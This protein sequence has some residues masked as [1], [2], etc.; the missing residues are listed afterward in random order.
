MKPLRL[1]LASI[2]SA[3]VYPDQVL[4]PED[5][6]DANDTGVEHSEE[7]ALIEEDP[8]YYE[9]EYLP[10][11]FPLPV[12]TIDGSPRTVISYNASAAPGVGQVAIGFDFP[13]I[14]FADGDVGGTDVVLEYTSAG[15]VPTARLYNL[16]QK[17]VRGLQDQTDK[18]FAVESKSSG[19]TASRSV[20]TYFCNGTF[21]IILPTPAAAGKNTRW[22]FKNTGTGVLTLDPAG[23][24]TI[25]GAAT[26]SVTDQYQTIEVVSDGTNYFI[27]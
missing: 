3:E 23:S 21:T 14:E 10:A 20:G 7:L 26:F 16:L 15:S 24:V 18:L 22:A 25:D 9:L 17:H 5:I 11:R 12:V 8:P 13:I 27:L 1:T 19:F 2:T 6:R 4:V